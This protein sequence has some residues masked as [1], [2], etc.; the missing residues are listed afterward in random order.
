MSYLTLSTYLM[1]EHFQIQ[2]RRKEWKGSTNL[3]RQGP[4]LAVSKT[5][6]GLVLKS[7]IWQGHGMRQL[8][9]PLEAGRPCG[10]IYSSNAF[11]VFQLGSVLG[12]GIFSRLPHDRPFLP[13]PS[14]PGKRQVKPRPKAGTKAKSKAKAK[15][16]ALA[17]KDDVS[18]KGAKR[19]REE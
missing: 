2:G 6:A 7:N 8:R 11:A 4:L 1:P 16:K 15:A 19:P 14:K 3:Q 5:W 12:N 18:S 10:Q 9:E 13:K 17:G